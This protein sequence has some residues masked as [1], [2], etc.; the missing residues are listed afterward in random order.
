MKNCKL[1]LFD[2]DGTLLRSDKTVS[3]KNLKALSKCREKGVLIGVATSRGEQNTLSFLSKF[4][5]DILITSGGALVKLR[6]E[7]IY[8]AEF[9]EDE[10]RRIIAAVREVC[11]ADCEITAD[12]ANSHYWNYKTDPKEQ[13]PS[14]GSSIYTDFEDF[15][16]RSL[17]ICAE[18]FDSDRAER[19]M[20]LLPECDCKRFSDGYWYKFTKKGITKEKAAAE[21]CFKCGINADEII[22]FGDDF[23]DAGMLEFCGTGVAMGSAIDEI[24]AKADIVIGGNDEDS[25]AEFLEKLF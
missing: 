22:A 7:Y 8:R 19:L 5:P 1:L 21:V 2:L 17:K 18:I 25:I 12:T 16:K 14:W 10:T 9:S 24:K 13:D 3:E 20:G 11:G 23:A 15:E 6:D 4:T